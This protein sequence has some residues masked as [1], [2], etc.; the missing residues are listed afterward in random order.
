MNAASMI[1]DN[2]KVFNF[3]SFTGDCTRLC[4]FENIDMGIIGGL[5]HKKRQDV[6]KNTRRYYHLQ[7]ERF[8]I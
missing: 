7:K 8:N 3:K 4:S 6:A 2:N 5:N 1:C